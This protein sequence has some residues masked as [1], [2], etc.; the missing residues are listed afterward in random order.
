MS[1]P[2]VSQTNSHNLANTEKSA[3]HAPA[4]PKS[5][6]GAEPYS[7][8]TPLVS[9]VLTTYNLADCVREALE[10]LCAQ[11]YT[12]IEIIVVD[13]GSRDGTLEIVEEFAQGDARI[14][15]FQTEHVGAGGARNFGLS[16][17]QGDYVMILDGDDVFDVH[18][19]EYLVRHA[20]CT[21]AD[22][23]VCLSEEMDHVSGARTPIPWAV[24]RSQI[25]EDVYEGFERMEA[26][27]AKEAGADALRA[28]TGAGENASNSSVSH[29]LTCSYRTIPGNLFA[30]FMGWPW[31]KLYRTDFLRAHN[32]VFPTDLRHSEDLLFVYPA[33]LY[34]ERIAV[35]D[36]VLVAHRMGRGVSVSSSRSEHIH[37][38]YDAIVRMK[39]IVRAIDDSPALMQQFLN[40][41]FDWTL[42]NIE[43]LPDKEVARRVCVALMHNAYP[44]LELSSHSPAYFTQYPRSMARYSSLLLDFEVDEP[45]RGPLGPLADLPYGK[46]KPWQFANVF[47]KFAIR[48]R[49]WRARPT[50]W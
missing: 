25:S 24:K 11:S 10:S 12:H 39:A 18:M 48:W 38:F 47:E 22:V 35:V 49:T 8:Q 7:S 29:A 36:R 40:W 21:Q 17:V 34:A 20:E 44:E 9:I 45:D 27:G 5:A 50:E 14:R 46:Y 32:L 2:S 1:T 42:W 15:L 30:A 33:L 37:A 23:C 3:G 19:V 16:Q 28:A 41:A 6:R 13:D 31:D 26:R 4:R 43:T